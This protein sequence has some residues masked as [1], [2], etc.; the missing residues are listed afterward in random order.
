[1]KISKLRTFW[2]ISLAALYTANT[3]GQSI[4]M[5]MLNKIN[6]S[7]VDKTI[8]I[9]VNRVLNLA[10]VNCIIV[11]PN[12]VEP[13]PGQ[14]TIIMC[15]HSSALDIPLS[16]YAFRNHSLRMLAKKEMSKIPIIGKGMKASEF[17]FVDRKNRHQAIKDLNAMQELLKSGIV[18][19]IAPEGTRSPTEA[20]G[21]FKKGGFITAINAKATIIPIGIRGANNILPARTL[22]LSLD[23]TAEIHIGT[24]VDASKYTLETKEALIEKIYLQ[25]KELSDITK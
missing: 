2:I 12:H 15:N 19:W 3:C 5:R 22:Q 9:W 23:E 14:A 8:Q 18:M 1:M 10:K 21:T 7:W 17:P 13:K 24:P 6:R 4:I 16:L 25:I 11:N 20:L